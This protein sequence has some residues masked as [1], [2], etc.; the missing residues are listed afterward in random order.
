MK[1]LIAIGVLA[2]ACAAF[3][4]FADG[5]GG[6]EHPQLP[7]AEFAPPASPEPDAQP[8]DEFPD[9]RVIET[10]GFDPSLDEAP[11]EA[12]LPEDELRFALITDREGRP[13][14]GAD[15][16]LL[17]WD[18]GRGGG[19]GTFFGAGGAEEKPLR[20]LTSGPD[21]YAVLSP[22]P[23]RRFRIE[24]R[25]GQSAGVARFDQAAQ[26]EDELPEGTDAVVVLWPIKRLEVEVLD[27]AGSAAPHIRVQARTEG[28][29]DGGRGR[30]GGPGFGS[31]VSAWTAPES[32]T[33]SIEISKAQPELYDAKQIR[34]EA[35]LPGLEQVGRDVAPLEEG[36]TQVSL[37]IP[38]T[39]TL[40]LNLKDADQH[41]FEDAV[42]VSWFVNVWD[43]QGPNGRDRREAFRLRSPFGARDARGG[44][45]T[46][47]GFAPDVRVSVSTRA[48]GRVSESTEIALPAVAGPHEADAL[49]G[50]LE[51]ALSFTVVDPQGKPLRNYAL[52]IRLRMDEPSGSDQRGNMLARMQ[53]RGGPAAPRATDAE[54]RVRLLAR[55]GLAGS[56]EIRASSDRRGRGRWGR[57]STGEPLATR[58]FTPLAPG[59]NRELEAFQL[60]S[61]AILVA[62]R[63]VGSEGEPVAGVRVTVRTQP[64]DSGE[65]R[66]EFNRRGGRGGRGGG[67]LGAE[68][69]ASGAFRIFGIVET[70]TLCTAEATAGGIAS[71]AIPFNPGA[72]GLDLIVRKT[73][74]LEGR[75]RLAD[76]ELDVDVA[77]TLTSSS[78]ERETL[79]RRQDG[80]FRA[81]ELFPDTYTLEV[82]L[83]RIPARTVPGLVVP[84]GEVVRPDAIRDLLVGQDFFKARILV[85]DSAGAPVGRADVS[86]RGESTPGEGRARGGRGRTNGEGIWEGVL[87]HGDPVSVTVTARGFARQQLTAA[88]FPLTVTMLKGATLHLTFQ[89]PLPA[90]P[91]IESYRMAVTAAESG[92]GLDMGAWWRGGG[93]T[94]TLQ[95]GATEASFENLGPGEHVISVTPRSAER[96]RRGFRR[97]VELGRVTID[98]SEG[99]QEARLEFDPG[100]IQEL[101]SAPAEDRGPGRR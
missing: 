42:G 55:P 79:R 86:W 76:P 58:R 19:F 10:M 75:V 92:G 59:E 8:S 88:R 62:G 61:S 98:R 14:A 31:T 27:P 29:W 21:G 68:T 39:V 91:E 11:E 54:G 25:S 6:E 35:T 99:V 67:D 97:P 3:F 60:G 15:V 83:D 1:P 12:A 9:P 36:T 52:D 101:L 53:R 48:E 95:A 57:E 46:I 13:V 93:P 87:R 74:G 4:L 84:E 45:I 41:V 23:Q 80:S 33:A 32:G 18:R 81:R 5:A 44:R 82:R 16:R 100:D 70:G 49:V 77:L 73:G 37:R 28:R 71:E 17:R 56:I 96:G 24:A 47:G 69:D 63:V 40:V 38:D 34:I 22:L 2:A 85:R 64:A 94:R 90:L 26:P 50:D 78:G 66:P 20:T 7:I 43:R 89:A 51:P 30:G 72:T 65:W